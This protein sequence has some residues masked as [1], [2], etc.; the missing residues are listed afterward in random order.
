GAALCAAWPAGTPAT[1]YAWAIPVGL[2]GLPRYTRRVTAE[3]PQDFLDVRSHG[4]A[5]VAVCVPSARVADPAFNAGAHL[6]Q[7]EAVHR[8]GAHYAVCPELGLSSYTC[9]D[10]FFQEPLQRASRPGARR[11]LC[12]VPG[13]RLEQL[14][15]RRSVLPGAVA[16]RLTAGARAR[17]RRD[18]GLEH[19][20]L[21][22]HAAGGRRSAVQLRGYA[23]PRP[24]RRG[25]AE[26]VSAELSRVLRAARVPSRRRRARNQRS[27]ARP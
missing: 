5:R 23:V 27:P 1:T 9:G 13:A 7:L 6:E 12:G 20:D 3:A 18:R 4:F 8:A 21:R 11:A 17:R 24:A 16:A 14:H 2:C 25:S 19:V 10:L 15:M 22:R 26:G